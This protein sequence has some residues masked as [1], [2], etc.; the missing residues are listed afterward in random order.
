MGEDPVTRR[1]RVIPLANAPGTG[2]GWGRPRR[3]V[4]AWTLVELLLVTNPLQISSALRVRA[5]RW[6]GAEIGRGV[7]F[8][9][10]TRVKFP[11]KLTIGDDCWIGEGAWFHNQAEITV[12]H[13][14]V[15]SQ[16]AFLTTGSHAYADDMALQTA[17]IHVEA[18]AWIT[19]RCIVLGGVRIGRSALI[20]PGSVI[21]R[22]VPPN[23]ITSG[24]VTEGRPDRV[25][26]TE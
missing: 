12:E 2:A 1:P 26:F 17:P 16:E 10:R 20:R 24:H 8:R 7:V 9:P 21:S 14:V 18:G 19:S 25:R 6:F 3:V 11:W 5:L 13:D 22:D 4:Y 23:V 15:I